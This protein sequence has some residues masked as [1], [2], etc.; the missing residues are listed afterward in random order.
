MNWQPIPFPDKNKIYVDYITHP[1]RLSRFF[2]ASPYGPLEAIFQQRLKQ[3]FPREAFATILKQQHQAWG[4]TPAIE[5]NRQ[6]L[7]AP[8]TL[9]VV[10]GQQAGMLVSPLYTLYKILTT[11]QLTRQLQQTYPNYQFVPLFWME[12]DDS[13]F[14]EIAHCYFI[15]RDNHLTELRLE[16]PPADEGKPIFLRQL[17]AG[18]DSWR[19]HITEQVFPTE[20]LEPVLD[21]YFTAYRGGVPIA[22]AFARM[23][24]ALFGDQGLLVLNPS[25]AAVKALGTAIFRTAIEQ[26]H[27]ILETFWQRNQELEAA[28]YHSQIHLK[29]Q[30]TLLFW[31]DE[32]GKR[33]RLDCDREDHC[34][35]RYAD[36][37][38]PRPYPEVLEAIQATPERFTTNVALRPIFQ[39]AVVPTGVYVGGPAEIAYFAQLHALYPLFDVPMPVIYPR[40]RVTIVERKIQKIIQKYAI[41]YRQLFEENFHFLEKDLA[42]RL[43]EHPLQQ[44]L[45]QLQHTIARELQQLEPAV[46]AFDPTLVKPLQHTRTSMEQALAKFYQKIQRSLERQEATRTQQLERLLVYLFPRHHPQERVLA[47]FYFQIKYGWDFWEKLLAELP[48]DVRTHWVVEL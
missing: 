43:A 48:V 46:Q 33:V 9:A 42:R 14:R 21:R 29:H 27:T 18:I 11:L 6:R 38:R 35:L 22:T 40:H 31:I 10:T 34:L 24:V 25:D 1:E 5:A 20:F 3:S 41:D 13:D 36:S 44:Q 12:V 8:N 39:D 15:N 28:G 4:T 26:R 19:Q 32:A 47:P 2:P 23:L 37:G 7:T 30:Q 16:A 17:P 45:N